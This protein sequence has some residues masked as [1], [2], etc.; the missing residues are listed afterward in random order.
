[1][2]ELILNLFIEIDTRIVII[3][4]TWGW[5]VSL[6]FSF[7]IINRNEDKNYSRIE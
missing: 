6:L 4:W 7:S 2:T 3:N 5:G 1:M